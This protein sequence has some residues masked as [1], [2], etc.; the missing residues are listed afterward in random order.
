MKN[1]FDGTS[2]IFWAH[3]HYAIPGFMLSQF[4]PIDIIHGEI[5][6][7]HKKAF[8]KLNRFLG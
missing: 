8:G 6:W 1:D 7:Y 2:N 5:K 4:W 3:E